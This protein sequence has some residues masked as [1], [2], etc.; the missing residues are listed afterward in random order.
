MVATLPMI[1]IPVDALENV[2]AP[3]LLLTPV[4]RS[5]NENEASTPNVLVIDCGF[6]T[7]YVYVGAGSSGD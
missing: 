6:N 2:Y 3:V 5:V 4:S 1:L 7:V